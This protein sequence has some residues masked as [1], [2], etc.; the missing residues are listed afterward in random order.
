MYITDNAIHVSRPELAALCAFAGKPGEDFSAVSFKLTPK[1][2]HVTAHT[3]TCGLDVRFPAPAGAEPAEFTITCEALARVRRSMIGSDVCVIELRRGST[4][5]VRIERP[6]EDDA[7]HGEVVWRTQWPS[8]AVS[9]QISMDLKVD[10]VSDMIRDARAKA[11]GTKQG[12]GF[13]LNRDFLAPLGLVAGAAE[14][15]GIHIWPAADVES[16]ITFEAG[17]LCTWTGIIMPMR[18]LAEETPADEQEAHDPGPLVLETQESPAA[19]KRKARDSR[20]QAVKEAAAAAQELHKVIEDAG[21]TLTVSV[22][23]PSRP[24]G[25]GRGK[26]KPTV[27][28]EDEAEAAVKAALKRR[29]A[30]RR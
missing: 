14:K 8:G 5:W 17:E 22:Q 2:A 6:G 24:K 20:A 13:V 3:G 28:P 26:A 29:G 30:K 18:R 1:Q 15:T 27:D 11:K 16:P 21:A 9:S 12:V 23:E 25:K 10:I 7:T 19:L 4:L